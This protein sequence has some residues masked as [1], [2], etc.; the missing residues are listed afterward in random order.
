MTL[1]D[2]L[3]ILAVLCS[4]LIAVQV[5]QHLN[6]QSKKKRRKIDI[7]RTLMANRATPN[8]PHAVS[9]F[10]QIDLEFNKNDPNDKGV[11]SAWRLYYDHISSPEMHNCDDQQKWDSWAEQG[12]SLL[13]DL[14]YEMVEYLG[15]DFDKV[16]LKRGH[17]YPKLLNDADI[18]RQ[19]INRGFAQIMSGNGRF[20]IHATVVPEKPIQEP[21]KKP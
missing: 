9:A 7:F 5:T 18:Q 15:Y 2:F 17:Y 20:P 16:Q 6:S 11:I 4:P 10:N 3:M 1:S 13:I 8:S 14:L 12:R 21:E 19:I